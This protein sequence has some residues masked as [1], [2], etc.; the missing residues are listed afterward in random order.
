MSGLSD[1]DLHALEPWDDGRGIY[2]VV[3]AIVQRAVAGALTEAADELARKGH[4]SAVT[5]V[6]ARIT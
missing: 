4:R 3:E 6:R 5:R 1:R 2:A